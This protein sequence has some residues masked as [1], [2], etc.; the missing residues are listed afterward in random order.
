[1][2]G[3]F[4][5]ISRISVSSKLLFQVERPAK[6]CNI[7]GMASHSQYAATAYR[8]LYA[9]KC[10]VPGELTLPE[11]QRVLTDLGFCDSVHSRADA[12]EYIYKYDSSLR[13]VL[14]ALARRVA[15]RFPAVA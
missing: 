9:S 2:A 13:G 15:S 4:L 6:R 1:M 12:T 3:S 10:R 14:G 8:A 7:V 5:L 11:L